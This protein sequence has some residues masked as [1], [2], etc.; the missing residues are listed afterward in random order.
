M[1]GQGLNG[2]GGG[3]AKSAEMKKLEKQVVEGN[4]AINQLKK[5]TNLDQGIKVIASLLDKVT[6]ARKNAPEKSG[7]SN[8]TLASLVGVA[9]TVEE[10]VGVADSLKSGVEAVEA[11]AQLVS[12]GER[13]GRSLS[14]QT[15]HLLAN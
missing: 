11:A 3:V 5:T 12:E 10:A 7:P 14:L 1:G 6:D 4:K 9:E 15:S 8:K 2:R 13:R